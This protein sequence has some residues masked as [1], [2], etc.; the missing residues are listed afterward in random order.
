M[1]ACVSLKCMRVLVSSVGK[2]SY[3][4]VHAC[5]RL[6]AICRPFDGLLS[7]VEPGL[8]LERAPGRL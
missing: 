5:V 2:Y 6:G 1:Y 7:V 8:L 4:C 3:M